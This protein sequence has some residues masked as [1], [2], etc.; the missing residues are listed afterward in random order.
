MIYTYEGCCSK[1]QHERH[2]R[3]AEYE[4]D[5]G[6][7]C[8]EC[9]RPLRRALTAPRYL[10][11]TKPFEAFK[12]TVDGTIISSHR[13]LQ[14]HNKRNNVVNLH[15]GYDEKALM[16]MTKKDHYAAL[17]AERRVDLASDMRE[18]VTKLEQGYK[19][20]PAPEGDIVP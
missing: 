14:E 4:A 20:Q 13:E 1:R 5:P 9:G 18:A 10:N 3:L 15:D 12:S 7:S 16:N 8:P 11:N 19:P 2:C 17:D 6:Y